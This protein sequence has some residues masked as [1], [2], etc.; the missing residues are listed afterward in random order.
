MQRD[1]G[2]L[3]AGGLVRRDDAI[4]ARPQQ[5]LL[6]VL[7]GGPR[8]DQDVVAQLAGG[9]R[10]EDVL[11]VGVDAR[12]HAPGPVDARLL[13][14]VVLGGLVLD[15]RDPRLGGVLTMLGVH[16]DHDERRADPLQ[17]T[18]DLA[19][20]AAESA[21]DV[22]VGVGVDH[23]LGAPLL[24]QA[25]ELARDEELRHRRQPVEERTYAEQLEAGP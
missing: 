2:H 5:L 17:V 11:G 22:V 3:P 23:L 6:G 25:A 10:D 8:D 13:E 7:R 1:P 9:Q 19:A 15:V 18:G 14:H 16:V 21:D 24:E 20:D 4:G 12:D